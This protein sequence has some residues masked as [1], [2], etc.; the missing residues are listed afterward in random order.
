MEDLREEYYAT[1]ARHCEM[2]PDPFLSSMAALLTELRH[3]L[4]QVGL[5]E[6]E[7]AEQKAGDEEPVE[8]NPYRPGRM[9]FVCRWLSKPVELHW[10]YN[11]FSMANQRQKVI[12]R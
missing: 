7:T 2:T 10:H 12:V 11:W 4:A 8:P 6:Q 3:A 1:V 9:R 5:F